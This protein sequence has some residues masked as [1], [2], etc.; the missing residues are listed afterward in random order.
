MGIYHTTQLKKKTHFFGS[1]VLPLSTSHP[2]VQLGLFETSRH[3]PWAIRGNSEVRRVTGPPRNPCHLVDFH[4]VTM[5]QKNPN[6]VRRKLG[7]C[8]Y[9]YSALLSAWGS[10]WLRPRLFRPKALLI[11]MNNALDDHGDSAIVFVFVFLSSSWIVVFHFRVN[12][13]ILWYIVHIH[14]VC[15]CESVAL[16]SWVLLLLLV[17]LSLLLCLLLLFGVITYI[18]TYICI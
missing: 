17:L 13:D 14:G 9:S 1:E 18:Y 5:T 15:I 10:N 2:K 4:D 16:L 6:P 7:P 12:M 8:K 3:P 11:D